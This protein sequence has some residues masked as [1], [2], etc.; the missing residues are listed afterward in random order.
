[1]S[2]LLVWILS[3]E[4]CVA[5][6]RWLLVCAVLL[7]SVI[8]GAQP[9]KDVTVKAVIDGDTL[10]VSA[11][12]QTYRIR[13][14]GV[15]APERYDVV[16]CA[17]RA[18]TAATAYLK[19]LVANGPIRLAFDVVPQDKYKRWLAYVYSA[20]I[21]V[22]AAMLESGLAALETSGKNRRHL[23]LFA[24]KQAEAKAENRGMWGE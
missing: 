5:N 19:A 1:M 22:N 13:L 18:A 11:D 23:P 15:G 2:G 9:P 14:I 24:Q 16:P 21:F 4:M 3:F 12:G 6:S 8:V 7:W 17:R 20:D 10:D